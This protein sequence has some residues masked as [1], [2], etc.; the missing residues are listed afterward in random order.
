[1]DQVGELDGVLDEEHRDVVGHDV[2]VA[3]LGVKFG[4]EAAHV[5]GQVERALV[6]DHRREPHEHR[7][8]LADLGQHLGDG[9][10]GKG[11]LEREGPVHAVPAGVD[12]ALGNALVVEVEDLLPEVEVLQQRRPPRADPQRVLVIG[13]RRALL[14]GQHR[15]AFSGDLVQ[16]SAFADLGFQLR[17]VRRRARVLADHVSHCPLLRLQPGRQSKARSGGCRRHLLTW[18]QG[19]RGAAHGVKRHIADPPRLPCVGLRGDRHAERAQ[20]SSA[21]RQA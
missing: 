17:R 6:A 19:A 14:G 1:V 15:I 12:D 3:L 16:L 5:A 18:A 4:R 11:L 13:D 20:S 9:V 8:L 10:V 7:R 2:P 21:L